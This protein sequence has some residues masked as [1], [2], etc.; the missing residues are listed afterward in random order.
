MTSDQADE[1]T[2]TKAPAGWHCTREAG[3]EGPCAAWPDKPDMYAIKPL[4]HEQELQA[5]GQLQRLNML[6]REMGTRPTCFHRWGQLS[7]ASL[8]C[9][10]CGG[11]LVRVAPRPDEG[12]AGAFDLAA[13]LRRLQPPLERLEVLMQEAHEGLMA[14]MDAGD[15][16]PDELTRQYQGYLTLL[17]EWYRVRR[18]QLQQELQARQAGEMLTDRIAC[19]IVTCT[20]VGAIEQAD[21][22]SGTGT[23]H[24][25]VCGATLLSGRPGYHA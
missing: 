19:P 11:Y 10:D 9:Y 20:W 21:H 6:W 2:C 25:P 16:V 22:H 8:V 13:V 5:F 23:F 18:E 4:T 1:A 3:H 7:V 14:M 15:A 12:E 17:D 24:C